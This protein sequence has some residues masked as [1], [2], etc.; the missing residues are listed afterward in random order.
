MS[1]KQI[2]EIETSKD[3]ILEVEEQIRKEE[4]EAVMKERMDEEDYPNEPDLI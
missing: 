1:D 4:I 2:N 3:D